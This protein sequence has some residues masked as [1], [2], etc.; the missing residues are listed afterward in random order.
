MGYH[1]GGARRRARERTPSPSVHRAARH[2]H[3]M[4]RKLNASETAAVLTA[5]AHDEPPVTFDAS[6]YGDSASR[7]V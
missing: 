1:D 4:K 7:P 3:H 5:A 2:H 6:H